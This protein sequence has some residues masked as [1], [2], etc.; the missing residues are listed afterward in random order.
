[1]NVLAASLTAAHCG[2]IE[3]DTSS[4]SDRS[5][6]RRV[7]SP[8]LATVTVLML[9]TLMNVV[10]S[11]RRRRDGD[12]VDAGR[13]RSRVDAKKLAAAVGSGDAAVPRYPAGSWP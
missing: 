3:L 4:T 2:P 6:I 8:V 12:D 11:D 1:M 13:R 9:A 10:G 7:A 5:T